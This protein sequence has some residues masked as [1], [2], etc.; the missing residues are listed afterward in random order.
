MAQ[1]PLQ[2]IFLLLIFN[3][4]TAPWAAL[5]SAASI[6]EGFLRYLGPLFI[7]FEGL[8]SLIV[9]QVGGTAVVVHVCG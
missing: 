3:L 6:W 7:A 8:A 5:L 9:A 4:Y 1:V 2:P